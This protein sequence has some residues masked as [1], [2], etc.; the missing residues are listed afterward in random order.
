MGKF[1]NS[2]NELDSQKSIRNS[3]HHNN[4]KPIKC[5]M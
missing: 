3:N 4:E 2:R 5:L 1:Q